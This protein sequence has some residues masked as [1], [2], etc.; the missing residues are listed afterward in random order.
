VGCRVRAAQATLLRVVCVDG[1]LVVDAGRRLPGRGASV[2]P[3]PRCVD[4]AD[5]RRAFIRALRLAGALD[6]TAVREHVLRGTARTVHP[7][8]E[9]RSTP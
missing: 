3:D 1:L 2:H 7:P 6:A 4:L 5:T 9:S 8:D